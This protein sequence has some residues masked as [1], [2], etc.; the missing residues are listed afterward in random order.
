MRFPV[1]NPRLEDRI[2]DLSQS[3]CEVKDPEEVSRILA[4]LRAAIQEQ[5]ERLRELA[6]VKLSER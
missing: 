3:A 6:K 5:I 4:E 1:P 2:R